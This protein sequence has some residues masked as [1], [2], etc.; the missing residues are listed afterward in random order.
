MCIVHR[1]STGCFQTQVLCTVTLELVCDTLHVSHVR[2]VSR[3]TVFA[4]P[5][6]PNLVLKQTLL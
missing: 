1:Q 6:T 3:V 5:V 2:S 4:L